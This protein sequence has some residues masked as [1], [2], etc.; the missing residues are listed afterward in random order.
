L[1]SANLQ[2]QVDWLLGYK[3]IPKGIDISKLSDQ[4]FAEKA[5]QILGK[6]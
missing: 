6:V 1:S 2:Q 3:Y 4:T 5:T